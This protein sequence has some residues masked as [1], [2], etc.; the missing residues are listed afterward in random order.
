MMEDWTDIIGTELENIEEPLPADDWSVLQQKYAASVRRRRTVAFAWV[1]G[2]MAAAA[3]AALLLVFHPQPETMIEPEPHK[4]MAEALPDVGPT[5]TSQPEVATSEQVPTDPD[6]HLD[7][8]PQNAHKKQTVIIDIDEVLMESERIENEEES[9]KQEITVTPE[10]DPPVSTSDKAGIKTTDDT[11]IAVIKQPDSYISSLLAD[12]EMY[13]ACNETRR[14]ISVGLSGSIAESFSGRSSYP[15]ADN[16]PQRPPA[17][18]MPPQADEPQDTTDMKVPVMK[19]RQESSGTTHETPLSFGVSARISLSDRLSLTTG[20]N[21][22]RYKAT[23]SK[24]IFAYKQTAH[25]LGIPVRLDLMLVNKKHFDLYLGVGAQA[26]KCIY[27]TYDSERLREKEV[28]F[29]VN[30]ALGMQVD[31]TQKVGLYFEPDIAWTLNEGT[32]KTSRYDN[33]FTITLRAGLRFNF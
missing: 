26:D 19:R 12:D 15:S 10:A 22:T 14:R 20:L 32:I 29:S 31:I 18:D 17:T 16:S 27:A 5:E 9:D 2:L 33:P 21:Y 6:Q 11:T 3:V 4:L 1:G 25:Y 7:I 30:G 8:I 28:L 23:I 24:G 13:V